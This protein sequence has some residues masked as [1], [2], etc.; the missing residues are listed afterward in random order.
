MDQWR[1]TASEIRR[2]IGEMLEARM[3]GRVG[4]MLRHFA[5]NAVF[6]CGSS[7]EGMLPPGIWQGV[8][9][10]RSV[11]R[12]S[13]ENYEPLDYEICDI[14]VEG[15]RAAVHWRSTW[16][17]IGSRKIYEIDAAHFLRWNVDEALVVEM[18][19]FF[20]RASLSTPYCHRLPGTEV[21]GEAAAG[22]DRAEIVQRVQKLAGHPANGP[23]VE[24][25]LEICAPDVVC[26]FVG[27][28]ARI[29]YA[30]RHRG[31]EALV[32]LV[33]AVAVDFE[34]IRC[35][36]SET[37]IEGGLVAGLR[38]VEWRHRG[39]GRH[40][41]VDLANFVRFEGGLAVELVEF[42][43]SITLLEMQGELETPLTSCAVPVPFR[44]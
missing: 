2:R 5:P 44:V 13:D 43:D 10:L 24:S 38:T 22:L 25:L 39:T 42:R 7:R 31:V 20:Q 19:E 3:S 36:I 14:I 8:E 6:H 27:D 18:H 9:A 16:R 26:D 37:L 33:R 12:R 21:I 30:G 11:T 4:V 23:A 1:L 41:L 28:R 34:Q 29:P 17:S 40:G 35:E 32:N 15:E